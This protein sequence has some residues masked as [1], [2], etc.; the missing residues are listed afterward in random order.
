[1]DKI[2][3]GAEKFAGKVT[4]NTGMYQRGEARA[5]SWVFSIFV[6]SVL[7]IVLNVKAG[8]APTSKN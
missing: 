1:M 4:S 3:G 5:V 6:P 2:V 8:D 7:K